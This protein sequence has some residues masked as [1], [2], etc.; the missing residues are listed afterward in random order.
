MAK[1]DIIELFKIHNSICEH[2]YVSVFYVCKEVSSSE[3]GLEYC[4]SHNF[5]IR[6]N[7]AAEQLEYQKVNV[8]L[9]EAFPPPPPDPS[10][11]REI[12]DEFCKA[13]SPAKF[14]EAGCAVCGSLTLQSDLSELSSLNTD[15]NVLNGAGHGFTQKERKI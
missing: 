1:L 6:N 3:R 12:I 15:L 5:T 13:T 14:E 2:Q 7:H 11:R 8:S 4:K 10:L 9:N